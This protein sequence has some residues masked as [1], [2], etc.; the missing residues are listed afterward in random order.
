[1]TKVEVTK[2]NKRFGIVK[3]DANGPISHPSSHTLPTLVHTFH[4][5]THTQM[6]KAEVTSSTS[7]S[8]L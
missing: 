2:F 6:M 3:M 7:A 5:S 1:M 8:A 4:P